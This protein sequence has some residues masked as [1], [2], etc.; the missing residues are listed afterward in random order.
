MT[1]FSWSR[2]RYDSIAAHESDVA[3]LAFALFALKETDGDEPYPNDSVGR[4]AADRRGVIRENVA[5][6]VAPF[7]E[8]LR[9][10]ANDHMRFSGGPG[11]NRTAKAS[12][13][14]EFG[15]P[16]VS[17]VLPIIEFDGDAEIV[18]GFEPILAQ[19][20][21]QLVDFPRP[22]QPRARLEGQRRILYDETRVAMRAAADRAR[23]PFAL[24]R[25]VNLGRSQKPKIAPIPRRRDGIDEW[26]ISSSR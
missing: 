20:R 17:D 18:V 11:R 26:S 12:F 21:R 4:G 8:T 3:V 14:G 6:F 7:A 9:A 24:E 2:H 15:A 19:F 22:S 16:Q 23:A 10:G 13:D 1:G 5:F 25:T